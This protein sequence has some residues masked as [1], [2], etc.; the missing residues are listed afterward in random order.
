MKLLVKYALSFVS[1]VHNSYI[2]I[3]ISRLVFPYV[4]EISF[5]YELDGFVGVFCEC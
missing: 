3:Y 4:R 5:G 1:Y 2:Y